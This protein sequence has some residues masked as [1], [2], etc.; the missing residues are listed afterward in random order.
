[1]NILVTGGKGYLGRY[2]V[3]ELLE[4]G[5]T[6]INYCREMQLPNK[7]PKNIFELGELTDLS[8][9]LSVLKNR[10]VERIIHTA[11]QSH[12]DISLF[13]PMATVE[14]N[15]MGLMNVF[16][17]ARLSGVKRVVCYSSDAAYGN[18]VAD[19]VTEAYPL[20][21]RTPYGVTKAA[22]EMMARAYNWCYGMDII[23]LRC[24]ALYGPG[25]VM[26]EY[27]RD[28]IKAARSGKTFTLP[29]GRDQK[30]NLVYVTDA[31][32]ASIKACFAKKR[33]DFSA[34]NITSGYQLT[35]EEIMRAVQKIIPEALFD[36]GEGVIEGWDQ[37]GFFS[38]E[39]AK[40]DLGY[41]PKVT[42]EE[43]LKKYINWLSE[44]DF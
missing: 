20:C 34:Y 8:R 35:L 9:L 30:F 31:A 17:A 29:S 19:V 12:P 10:H 37:H 27:V 22:A 41:E 44:N 21:P 16:E 40:E 18:A 5:H 42:F 1:M 39:A 7:N 11:A 13:M 38:I 36:V 4:Q 14:A 32:E 2:I 15:T 3:E 28:V 6:V 23:A 24:C 25:Q 33:S 43:G 26:P